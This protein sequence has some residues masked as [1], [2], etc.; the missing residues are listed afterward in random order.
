MI[1]WFIEYLLGE[2]PTLDFQPYI[3]R[4]IRTKKYLSH[5]GKYIINRKTGKKSLSHK[6]MYNQPV[7]K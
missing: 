3:E 7:D 2:K 1:Y 4:D 5:D 6:W